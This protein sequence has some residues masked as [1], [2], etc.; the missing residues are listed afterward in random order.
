M[1]RSPRPST[2]Q[3]RT[4]FAPGDA[5]EGAPDR[6]RIGPRREH[7]S[8][9]STST[10]RCP[11]RSD[12]GRRRGQDAARPHPRVRGRPRMPPRAI[13]A[14]SGQLTLVDCSSPVMTADPSA[15]SNR[16]STTA[17]ASLLFESRSAT[18]SAPRPNRRRSAGPC[19]AGAGGRTTKTVSVGLT[20]N[21]RPRP[22]AAEG[23][24][25]IEFARHRP[26]RSAAE[27]PYAATAGFDSDRA[28]D[29]AASA[30]TSNATSITATRGIERRAGCAGRCHHELVIRIGLLALSVGRSGSPSS[31]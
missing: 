24:A 8:R 2:S 1:T 12:H 20:N 19:P 18:G 7:E 6:S 16:M 4:P 3:P 27:C 31:H 21:V 30:A 23:R 5:L 29:A 17:P 10:S 22:C 15:P 26:R 25:R 28:P 11:G 14:G 13:A 9:C